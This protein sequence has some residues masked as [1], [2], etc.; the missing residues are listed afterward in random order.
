MNTTCPPGAPAGPHRE[1]GTPLH[2]RLELL[3]DPPT[4]AF[5]ASHARRTWTLWAAGA[6]VS[7]AAIVVGHLESW[8]PG[9]IAG[10]VTMTLATAAVLLEL[11][12][13]PPRPGWLELDLDHRLLTLL[14]AGT[15]AN[16]TPETKDLDE[17]AGLRI[18][19]RETTGT[20]RD[21]PVTLFELELTFRDASR[22]TLARHRDIRH[23]G[24][25]MAQVNT[26]MAK[27]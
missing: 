25:V 7:L 18:V 15:D 17:V 22:H 8:L 12:R 10:A 9:S 16:T 24:A 1:R 19:E 6:T 4:R 21:G 5:L 2:F 11:R 20:R 14:P 3:P 23:L 27:R 13:K 26:L